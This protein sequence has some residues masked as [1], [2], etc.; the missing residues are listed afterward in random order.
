MIFYQILCLFQHINKIFATDSLFALTYCNIGLWII[1]K[2]NDGKDTPL[3]SRGM[4]PC[5]KA[6][7]VVVHFCDMKRRRVVGLTVRPH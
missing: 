4:P 2:M 5:K 3:A 6:K 7:A 1:R